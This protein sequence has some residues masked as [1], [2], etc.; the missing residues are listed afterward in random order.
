MRSMFFYQWRPVL[1]ASVVLCTVLAA[2]E[3]KVA[4]TKAGEFSGFTSPSSETLRYQQQVADDMPD[5]DVDIDD[6]KRGFLGTISDPLIKNSAGET[7]WN[8]GEYEFVAGDA[9]A[10][11]NPSLW[12]QAKINN[13]HG[14]FQVTDRVYQVRGFD[15]ANMT[16]IVGDN[17]WVLVDPLTSQE[18]AGAALA[19][20]RKYLGDAP[21][22]AVI[23]THSHVDHFAGIWGVIDKKDYD[24]GKVRVIAPEGFLEE[25]TSENIIAGV[26]MTRRASFMY[27]RR[28]PKHERGHV[29]SGLGK[30]PAYG[31]LGI[32]E[33]TDIIDKTGQRLRIAGLE[34]VFQNAP[35]SEAP[36]E[37]T[38]AI[39]ALKVYCGAEVATRTLHNLYTLR[40]AKVRDA[41]KWTHYINQM[42]ALSKNSD[43]F[44]M[45]HHWPIWGRDNIVHYLEQQRDTYKYIHDQTVRLFNNGFTPKEIS[46]RLE[47]PE[48]LRQGYS[49][50]DYY[51]TISHNSK[52]VYQNYMGWYDGNPA[53]LNPLPPVEASKRY[54]D[55]A[56]GA[57]AVMNNAQTAFEE[58]EYRWAAQ[59]LNHLVFAE[60]DSKVAK[61]LLAKVYDQLGYQSESGPWRDEYLSAA[62][63]LRHGAPE[64]LMFDISSMA[65]ILEQ[66]PIE[67]F[68]QS[69]SVRLDAQKAEGFE[70]SIVVYFTDTDARYLLSI[71]NSVFH[72]QAEPSLAQIDK[73]KAAINITRRMF[74]RML[75][76]DAGLR[77]MLGSNELDVSGNPVSLLR[78]FSMFEKPN[79]LFNVVTP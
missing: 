73:S 78:F 18:T 14:L 6:A 49:N 54:V 52:A 3:R 64:T 2:C 25:A 1:V 11:V 31:T 66:T 35:S 62:F 26:A 41:L 34:F 9:P 51:G 65:G 30:S 45:S 55:L 50:R 60:P 22:M 53:N 38:F 15:L 21:V 27:G 56:G 59:L 33:P 68:F 77:E 4:P 36:A 20:A 70:S 46:E 75:L 37:L 8:L 40:G 61:T 69:M 17:G 74:L 71:K 47:L 72:Y 19:V 24:E 32:V 79:E 43:V 23:I 42:I 58:G 7:V 10:S 13:L 44:I 28:L 63:E 16:I 76:G 29:D 5:T 48:S 39:P 57:Q 12:R 67:K